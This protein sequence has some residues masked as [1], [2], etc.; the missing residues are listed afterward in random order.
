VLN[1]FQRAGS[2]LNARNTPPAAAEPKTS[3]G[4]GPL[5]DR[6]QFER[7]CAAV[8]EQLRGY[9]EERLSFLRA[10]L[11][12]LEAH[13]RTARVVHDEVLAGELAEHLSAA[14]ARLE[15]LT[16]LRL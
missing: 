8:L 16:A 13:A 3:E 1:S 10:S 9:R 11:Q 2:L 15:Q 5:E 14:Q 6:E 7:Y 12:R 4:T